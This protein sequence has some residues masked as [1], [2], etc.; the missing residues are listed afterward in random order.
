MTIT[1]I[2]IEKRLTDLSRKIEY[3]HDELTEADEKELE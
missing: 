2:Q 3:A 1:L